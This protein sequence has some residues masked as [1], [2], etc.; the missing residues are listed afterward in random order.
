LERNEVNR[1]EP[2]AHK[3]TFYKAKHEMR[4]SAKA[5][6]WAYS[7]NEGKDKITLPSE[8]A[9]V[10]DKSGRGMRQRSM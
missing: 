2:P 9:L 6:G 3:G 10:L 1:R 8:G 5:V 7:S 4:V